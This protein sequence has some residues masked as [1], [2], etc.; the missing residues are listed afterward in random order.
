MVVKHT[1]RMHHRSLDR[2][3][4]SRILVNGLISDSIFAPSVH[5]TEPGRRFR[6]QSPEQ[7]SHIR[8]VLPRDRRRPALDWSKA[9]SGIAYTRSPSTG[10]KPAG[11]EV[12]KGRITDRIYAQSFHGTEAGRRR[13]GQ[14]P[15][16]GT[17]ISPVCPRD[18]SRPALEWPKTES[19]NAYPHIP[20]T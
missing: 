7:G 4:A 6:G 10:Q 14:R 12:V 5:G 20:S 11:A 2:R 9:G 18:R 13:S 15:A 17:Q 8:A 1:V 3:P 16:Q 19:A